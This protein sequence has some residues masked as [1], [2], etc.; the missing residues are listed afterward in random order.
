[1]PTSVPR[2]PRPAGVALVRAMMQSLS[3]SSSFNPARYSISDAVLAGQRDGSPSLWYVYAWSEPPLDSSRSSQWTVS[4]PVVASR[5][6]DSD[7]NRGRVRPARVAPGGLPCREITS[8]LHVRPC[9]VE[10]PE[11]L[12]DFRLP[13][14]G[15]RM[16]IG[17]ILGLPLVEFDLN[18][19]GP[20]RPIV[21]RGFLEHPNG[22]F[23]GEK[24][25]GSHAHRCEDREHHRERLSRRR[26]AATPITKVTSES[27]PITSGAICEPVYS[28]LPWL[29]VR[30]PTAIRVMT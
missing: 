12:I 5:S 19:L 11:R 16:G 8:D 4:R 30:Q 14:V 20:V 26:T 10:Q 13:A 17:R 6:S 7:N 9:T 3:A 27:P 1:M 28:P 22:R 15:G 29:S 2:L 25:G 23:N 24:A 21:L 18:G